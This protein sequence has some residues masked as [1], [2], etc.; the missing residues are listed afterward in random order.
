MQQL[1]TKIKLEIVGADVIIENAD[2]SVDLKK[3]DDG[4]PNY[5]TVTIYNLSENTYTLLN[6]KT[7]H[8]RVYTD[9]NDKGYVLLFQGDLRDIKKWKK[10]K[11][12]ASKRKRKSKKPVKVQYESPPITRET[13]GNDVATIIELQDSIKSTF[14]NNF[15]SQSYKDVVTNKKV[16]NDI[17][18]YIKRQTTIG[19]GNIAELTEKTFPKGYIVHGTLGNVLKQICRTGNCTCSIENNIV[20][21]FANNAESDVYG[22]YLHGGICPRPDF[23]ANKEVSIECPFLPSV[24]IGNFVKLDFQDIDGIYPIKKIESKIDN[25]GKE[26]ETKLVLKV[27]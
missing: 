22:Y 6:S 9:T 20:N 26:Y 17:I 11:A 21:I 2:I 12:T 1:Y 14:I 27:D 4:T 5:C 3:S 10:F 8:M 15:Y 25:F 18:Y 13:D 19:I 16:L 24:N 7:T 23:N